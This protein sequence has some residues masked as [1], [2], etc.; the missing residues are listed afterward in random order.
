MPDVCTGFE[1]QGSVFGGSY[2]HSGQTT[3]E[4]ECVMYVCFVRFQSIPAS[5]GLFCGL[6]P[7][8]PSSSI[9]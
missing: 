3:R 6:V 1:Q 8:L 7:Q 9:L 2:I 5:D 4:P